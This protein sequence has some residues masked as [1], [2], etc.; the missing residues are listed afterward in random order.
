MVAKCVGASWSSTTITEKV[1]NRPALQ[2][3]A[4]YIAGRFG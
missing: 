4:D 2:E 1:F 3:T